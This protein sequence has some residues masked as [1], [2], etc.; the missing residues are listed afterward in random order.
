MRRQD[1]ERA[2]AF[3]SVDAAFAL[4]LSVALFAMFSAMLY[5]AGMSAA[6]GADGES[7]ALLSARFS[8]YALALEQSGGS[9]DLQ[10]VLARTG[11][12]YASIRMAGGGGEIS[13]VSAGE[14]G[15]EVFCTRRIAVVGNKMERMEV[16]IG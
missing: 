14:K 5:S 10:S 15:S 1:D 2:R 9:V 7:G 8:S 3:W 13:F 12:G 16:C 4:V 11:R 6:R